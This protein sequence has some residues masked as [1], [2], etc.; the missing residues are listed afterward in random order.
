MLPTKRL[1]SEDCK[2]LCPYCGKDLNEGRCDCEVDEID[3]RFEVLKKLK[4]DAGE[5]SVT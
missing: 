4:F 2:G 5:G 3:P 1:C